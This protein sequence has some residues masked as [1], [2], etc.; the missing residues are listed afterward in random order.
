MG[1]ASTIASAV[2]VVN[3]LTHSPAAT[4]L[5]VQKLTGNANTVN[6]GSRYT[7]ASPADV[8]SYRRMKLSSQIE[9]HTKEL[10]NMCASPY[11][12]L[13]STP[14]PVLIQ[15]YPG[16]KPNTPVAQALQIISSV[17]AGLALANVIVGIT[18]SVIGSNNFETGGVVDT[19][20]A[21][22]DTSTTPIAIPEPPRRPDAPLPP[23]KPDDIKI[24]TMPN[25]QAPYDS[26]STAYTGL[27]GE[28][29]NENNYAA[30]NPNTTK[31]D[32]TIGMD[33][34]FV[35]PQDWNNKIEQQVT[36]QVIAE[37]NLPDPNQG[38][39]YG[40]QGDNSVGEVYSDY[41]E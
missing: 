16:I 35:D 36:D 21:N 8:Y 41:T 18:N 19:G 29:G 12:I 9:K 24:A 22:S 38:Y 25:P 2:G 7:T 15:K 28:F 11:N 30:G 1:I 32:P 3:M 23:T 40:Q 14:Y 13:Y 26:S 27:D 10:D 39:D 34:S 33:L 5:G 6:W 31:Y 37:P 20:A 4:S 17:E